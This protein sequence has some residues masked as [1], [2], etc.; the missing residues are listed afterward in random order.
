MIRIIAVMTITMLCFIPQLRAQKNEKEYPTNPLIEKIAAEQQNCLDTH[1]ANR[2]CNYDARGKY[3]K[4]LEDSYNRLLGTLKANLKEK[5]I[6][7]QAAWAKFNKAQ[8]D[9]HDKFYDPDMGTIALD[10]ISWREANAVRNRL[11]Q[12][13]E[14][15]QRASGIENKNSQREN[16]NSLRKKRNPDLV[17]RFE[18]EGS[19]SDKDI[20]K[21][22][23]AADNAHD[24]NLNKV[25]GALMGLM[26]R[27][28]KEA[29]IRAERE[30]IKFRDAEMEFIHELYATDSGREGI[31]D[32]S[33][34]S[35]EI[36][37]NRISEL[38]SLESE[39]RERQ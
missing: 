2:Q 32:T 10:F 24:K 31:I 4:A 37:R 33:F 13:D 15:I 22:A 7:T 12:I 16:I 26:K 20:L 25:Y 29:L 35:L 30:W 36:V 14:Y 27:P 8:S 6:K 17:T 3:E 19:F 23:Q 28:A 11:Y 38:D 1:E 5:L 21:C 9:F 34:L 39:L 18:A